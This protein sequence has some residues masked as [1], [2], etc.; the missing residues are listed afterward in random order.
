M[1]WLEFGHVE[2]DGNR[3][4]T[5]RLAGSD[6]NI[7]IKP[8]GWKFEESL[9]ASYIF[10]PEKSEGKSLQ[11]LRHENGLEVFLNLM[12]GKEVYLGRE[13]KIPPSSPTGR[14]ES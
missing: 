9:S 7:I 8:E 6:D 5:C 14:K 11:F 10:V 13:G 3:V 2:I 12:T 4:A 1:Y